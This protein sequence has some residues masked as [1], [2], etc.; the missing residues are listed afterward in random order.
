MGNDL[1]KI[2]TLTVEERLKLPL[3]KIKMSARLFNVLKKQEFRCPEDGKFKNFR[4]KNLGEVLNY[5][6]KAHESHFYTIP[7]CGKAVRTEL[8]KLIEHSFPEEF[9]KKI[10]IWNTKLQTY[11]FE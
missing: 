10:D 3:S 7:N 8:F 1:K 5:F 11:T 4:F 6:K 9:E 2:N